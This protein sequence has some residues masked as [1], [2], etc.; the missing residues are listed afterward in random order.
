MTV[1]WQDSGVVLS[2]RP[3]G[4]GRL[5]V[6]L[7]TAAHGRRCGLA[8]LSRSSRRGCSALFQPGN[9]VL[10]SWKARLEDQLGTLTGELLESVAPHF[11]D[12]PVALEAL[13]SACA[14]LEASLPEKQP[15]PGVWAALL[16][17]L[18]ALRE[19]DSLDVYIRWE[20]RLLADMGYGLDLSGCAVTG[21]LD[22]LVYVSP[23][24]G[25]AVSA[26]AGEPYR[27][28]LLA[29]PPF[30]IHSGMDA[31]GSALSDG[32][33][34]TGRFLEKY[35]L[36]SSQGGLPAVRRRLLERFLSQP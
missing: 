31:D 16:A 30:L 24:T 23:R 5:L 11:F 3:F 18:A 15:Y 32:L 2:V 6:S 20:I 21:A 4:E 33:R 12:R 14:V 13:S 8:T 17:L 22:D 34:L 7:L 1:G 19:R 9:V 28:R 27:D 35:L 25:R 26:T 36:G 29:L 10:V